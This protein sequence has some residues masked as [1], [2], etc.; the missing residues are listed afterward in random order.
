MNNNVA[1]FVPLKKHFRY[2]YS[3]FRYLIWLTSLITK[4][5]FGDRRDTC[6]RPAEPYTFYL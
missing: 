4:E 1:F 5:P 2:F 3:L 6:G